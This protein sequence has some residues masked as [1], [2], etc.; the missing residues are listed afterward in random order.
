M[1]ISKPPHN[2]YALYH[3]DDE[4][5]KKYT[6][7]YSNSKRWAVRKFYVFLGGTGLFGV[8]KEIA[9]GTVVR[10]G[11]QRL[12]I[13]VISAATYVCAPAL[14]VVTNATRVVKCCK[15]VYTTVSYGMELIEDTSQI[16]FLPIDLALFG[17]PISANTEG[18]FSSWSDI[19]DILDNLP[20][21]GD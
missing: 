14:V 6:I 15:L 17:Q 13:A 20:V 7:V 21:I 4:T 11:K 12:A 2:R 1:Q 9:K 10:Y 3:L 8:A 16:T 19:I 5:Y 18:R